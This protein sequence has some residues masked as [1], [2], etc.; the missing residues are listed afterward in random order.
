MP[1]VKT[2]V[3]RKRRVKR[4]LKRAKGYSGA[5]HSHMR[6]ALVAVERAEE[7]AK[8][9]RKLRKRDFRR[10]WITRISAAVKQ[11]GMNYSSFICGLKTAEVDMNRKQMSELAI[12]D[13]SAFDELVKIAKGQAD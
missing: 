1:R 11:R 7:H 6:T 4:I 12:A 5:R 8:F 2:N 10:L 13:P 9:G 3:A